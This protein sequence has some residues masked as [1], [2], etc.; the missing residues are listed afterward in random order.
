MYYAVLLQPEVIQE[1]PDLASDLRPQPSE[2]ATLSYRSEAFP[3]DLAESTPVQEPAPRRRMRT[4]SGLL[5]AAPVGLA[6]MGA[7]LAMLSHGH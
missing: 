4:L 3:E 7:V 1:L 2:P 5:M 6:V